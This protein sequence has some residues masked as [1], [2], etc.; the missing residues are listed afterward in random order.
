MATSGKRPPYERIVVWRLITDCR[1]KPGNDGAENAAPATA[2]YPAARTG[3]SS[4][5]SKA[6]IE[7]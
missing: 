1:V 6:W 5:N 2:L 7:K 3:R 4:D